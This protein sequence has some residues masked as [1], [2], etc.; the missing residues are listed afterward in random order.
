MEGGV[1]SAGEEDAAV[2][3]DW[4]AGLE[5]ELAAVDDDELVDSEPALAAADE[6]WLEDS[7]VAPELVGA[8]SESSVT[9][10]YFL[11]SLD[12]VIL[13]CSGFIKKNTARCSRTAAR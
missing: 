7:E 1:L 4:L 6:S 5:S 3:G 8:G 10:T 11:S 12:S 2:D 13:S 9:S